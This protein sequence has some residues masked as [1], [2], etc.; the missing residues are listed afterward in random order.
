MLP[1]V[2]AAQPFIGVGAYVL[3]GV[4]GN[5]Y[6]DAGMVTA[7]TNLG[8]GVGGA[9]FSVAASST[10]DL[11]SISKVGSDWMVGVPDNYVDNDPLSATSIWTGQTVYGMGLRNG[12]Y[13]WTLSSGSKFIVNITGVV[14]TAIPSLTQWGVALSAMLM[15]AAAAWRIQRRTGRR[16]AGPVAGQK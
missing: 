4:M 2:Q 11:T 1:G 13:E 15:L 10:G 9:V 7:V 14:P 3:G 12:T 8:P 6:S 16:A 5:D